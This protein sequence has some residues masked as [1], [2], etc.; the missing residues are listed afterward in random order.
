MRKLIVALFIVLLCGTVASAQM[1]G[2][3]MPGTPSPLVSDGSGGYSLDGSLAITATYPSTIANLESGVSPYGVN[4]DT[5]L[6]ANRVYTMTSLAASPILGIQGPLTP[7]SKYIVI[8]HTRAGDDSGAS[9]WGKD[10]TI[11]FG[12]GSSADSGTTIF[13]LSGNTGMVLQFYAVDASTLVMLPTD[14]IIHH[15]D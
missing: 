11:R 12:S 9:V 2:G 15:V 4:G 6:T 10:I 3:R 7:G 1:R 5:T 14:V 8:D 13:A